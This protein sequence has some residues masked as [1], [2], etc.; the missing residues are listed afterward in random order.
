MKLAE[1]ENCD[2][3][4]G[5]GSRIAYNS[6]QIPSNEEIIL[7]LINVYVKWINIIV[8]I[9][10]NYYHQQNYYHGRHNLP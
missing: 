1:E 10:E 2:E 6:L 9:R 8:I 3:G 4:C 5:E 7:M